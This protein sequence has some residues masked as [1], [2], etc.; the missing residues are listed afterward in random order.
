MS[1]ADYAPR[2]KLN[3]QIISNILISNRETKH[4]CSLPGTLMFLYISLCLQHIII[5]TS[6][7]R[8]TRTPETLRLTKAVLALFMSVKVPADV[9]ANSDHFF[10]LCVCV[11]QVKGRSNLWTQGKVQQQYQIDVNTV[12]ELFGQQDSQSNSSSKTSRS[13]FSRS[14]FREAKEEVCVCARIFLCVHAYVRESDVSLCLSL[15]LHLGPQARDEHWNLPEAIQ[16]VYHAMAAHAC[17]CVSG[18][19]RSLLAPLMGVMG[20]HVCGCWPIDWDWSHDMGSP[21]TKWVTGK[22]DS[23]QIHFYIQFL[24]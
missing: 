10:N 8:V 4:L 17:S 19:V 6:S 18:G 16:E 22:K 23:S 7:E 15:G 3:H 14:S 9:S 24:S 20:K 12:E 1:V 13:G 5:T 11:G 2:M 21:Q